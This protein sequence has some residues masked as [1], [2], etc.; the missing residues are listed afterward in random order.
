MAAPTNEAGLRA[1]IATLAEL[2]P[3]EAAGWT[4][5]ER[6]AL[7][8]LGRDRLGRGAWTAAGALLGYAA[9]LD[10]DSSGTW[11]LL[12]GARLAERR[13]VEA[14]AALEVAW[15][16]QRSWRRAAVAALCCERLGEVVAAE[17]WREAAR[18][19]AP[20]EA[21]ERRR[22]EQALEPLEVVAS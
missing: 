17:R 3:A 4:P 11:E 7:L 10:L 5:A 12:A 21:T 22:M 19:Q 2:R 13:W 8:R 15:S 18:G 9:L 16:L 6:A 14:L 20:V 1:A